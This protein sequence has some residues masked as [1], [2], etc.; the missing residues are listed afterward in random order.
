MFPARAKVYKLP[1]G[2]SV[3]EMAFV[4]PLSCAVH[5]VE[6]AD[7]QM[8]DVVVVGGCGPIGLGMISAARMRGPARVVAVDVLEGR[9]EVARKC[10]ADVVINANQENVGRLVREI[11]GGYGCDVYLEASGVPDGVKQGLECCRKLGVMVEFS[12]FKGP[13]S[14]DWSVI[15]DEKELNIR[16]AHCSGKRGYQVAMDMLDR[17]VVPVESIV[18]HSLPLEDVEHGLS[19]VDHP[20]DSIKVTVDPQLRA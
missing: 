8:G 1:R 2:L 14:V 11:T 18:T 3:A 10:G 15:G 12:V 4:E 19:L 20:C 5:G 6:R 13:T 7:V 16:G 9:L 17:G